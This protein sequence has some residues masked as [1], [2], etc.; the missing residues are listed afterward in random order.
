MILL[1]QC[2]LIQQEF[3]LN[4]VKQ[5]WE[6]KYLNLQKKVFFGD[7]IDDI[8]FK[9]SYDSLTL[10]LGKNISGEKVFADLE[11]M[12]HLINCWNNWFWKISWHKYNDTKLIA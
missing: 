11:K 6:L 3:L 12:P 7:L 1:E 4:Q 2:H 8:K 5:V 10:A 9:N